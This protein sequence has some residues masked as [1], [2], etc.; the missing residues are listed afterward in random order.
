MN[1]QKLDDATVFFRIVV[2]DCYKSLYKCL[3]LHPGPLKRSLCFEP[4]LQP[5]TS[6]ILHSFYLCNC[7]RV[8]DMIL[9]KNIDR[10]LL[11]LIPDFK[12]NLSCFSKFSILFS[13]G[14]PHIAY[15]IWRYSLYSCL[16]ESLYHKVVL[17]FANGS[18]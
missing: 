10:R 4:S 2:T 5:L 7:F 9:N 16:P 18:F 1:E 13:I 8:L 14:F 3:E 11:G 17:N 6:F 15:L 12:E